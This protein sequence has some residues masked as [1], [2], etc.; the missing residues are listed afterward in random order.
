MPDTLADKKGSIGIFDS[1]LGGLWILKHLR[2]TLPE[3]NYVFFGDQAH[4]PY[5]TKTKEE[6]F[7]YTTQ[8]LAFLY[9]KHNCACVLLA[10]NTT[11]SSIYDELRAWVLKEFPDRKLF[12]VVRPTI[13]AVPSIDPVV[14]FA[15]VRTVESHAYRDGLIREKNI[16]FENVYE[17]VVSELAS[18]IEHGD[19]TEKY[20][21]SCKHLVPNTVTTGI[22][23][24]THYGIVLEDFKKAFP[25]VGSWI[26]QEM[27]LPE[28]FKLYFAEKPEFDAQLAHDGKLDIFVT[29]KNSVFDAWLHRWYGEDINAIV[30]S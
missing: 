14:V 22:L 29:E 11:S 8:A 15:T 17:V 2:E 28:K 20:I 3:Y 23:G 6:L 10:C 30:I 13:L 7:T 16:P 21:A 12:G 26:C 19:D 1:G 4:V 27:I 9:G 18:R 25:R 24:C 5:G